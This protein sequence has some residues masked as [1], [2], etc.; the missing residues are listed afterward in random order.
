MNPNQALWEKGDFTRIASTMRASGEEIVDSLG[1]SEG[2]RVLDLGCGDG[3]TAVPAAQRGADV[4][5]VDIDPIAI[6]ATLAN[7]ATNGLSG[8]IRARPGSLPSGEASHDIVLANLIAS[9]LIALAPQLRDELRPG[10]VLVA[11]GVFV[12]RED[13]VRSAFASA[14]LEVAARSAEGDWVALEAVRV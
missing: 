7:A 5:G 6:D 10:G 1:V 9:V 4:L 13:E 8:V 3:T 11:S 12:D 14:G 2:M